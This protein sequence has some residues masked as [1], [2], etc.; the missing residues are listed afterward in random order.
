MRR[1]S[2]SVL[3]TC[4]EELYTHTPTVISLGLSR[5]LAA[6]LFGIEPTDPVTLDRSPWLLG[7]R[8]FGSFGGEFSIV[9]CEKPTDR[10]CKRQLL[11]YRKDTKKHVT[12]IHHCAAQQ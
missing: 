5:V 7:D 2:L 4:I 1:T 10:H 6:F 12:V 8:V 9:Q 3:S 11:R